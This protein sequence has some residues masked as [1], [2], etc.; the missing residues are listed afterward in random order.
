MGA[1]CQDLGNGYMRCANTPFAG[2]TWLPEAPPAEG[3][4]HELRPTFSSASREFLGAIGGDVPSQFEAQLAARR[5]ADG[6]NGYAGVEADYNAMPENAVTLD[7]TF[8]GPVIGAFPGESAMDAVFRQARVEIAGA[9]SLHGGSASVLEAE[10][11]TMIRGLAHTPDSGVRPVHASPLEEVNVARAIKLKPSSISDLLDPSLDQRQIVASSR[12]STPRVDPQDFQSFGKAPSFDKAGKRPITGEPTPGG[13]SEDD[14]C[15]RLRKLIE[16]GKATVADKWHY[17]QRCKGI[18]PD[19][20]YGQPFP[21]PAG[22]E[23]GD[24]VP[25]AEAP[26][27]AAPVCLCN[28]SCQKP[29]GEPFW[30]GAPNEPALHCTVPQD[31]FLHGTFSLTQSDLNPL[32]KYLI[33]AAPPGIVD[34]VLGHIA[35]RPSNPLIPNS[36]LG[37]DDTICPSDIPFTI[38]PRKPGR[39]TITGTWRNLSC[40]M[41]IR[42][43]DADLCPCSAICDPDWKPSTDAPQ[44]AITVIDVDEST[45]VPPEPV[46]IFDRLLPFEVSLGTSETNRPHQFRAFTEDQLL[47]LTFECAKDEPQYESELSGFIEC[48]EAQRFCAAPS[49]TLLNY[50]TNEAHAKTDMVSEYVHI[51]Y[52]RMG[53]AWQRCA[54]LKVDIYLKCDVA[55]DKARTE[56][57]NQPTVEFQASLEKPVSPTDLGNFIAQGYSHFPSEGRPEWGSVIIKPVVKIATTSLWRAPNCCCVWAKSISVNFIIRWVQ[58]K[59]ASHDLGFWITDPVVRYLT[60]APFTGDLEFNI[61]LRWGAL[62]CGRQNKAGCDKAAEEWRSYLEL[63]VAK[64]A[65]Y[66]IKSSEFTTRKCLAPWSDS[67]EGILSGNLNPALVSGGRDYPTQWWYADWIPDAEA[68]TQYKRQILNSLP[69]A[70]ANALRELCRIGWAVEFVEQVWLHEGE[71][72]AL[73]ILFAKDKY[74]ISCSQ[75][76]FFLQASSVK[77]V[78]DAISKALERLHGLCLEPDFPA[79]VDFLR[80]IDRNSNCVARET[81]ETAGRYMRAQKDPRGKICCV[82]KRF[83]GAV[84][85]DIQKLRFKQFATAVNA[86]V[87][88]LDASDQEIV[89]CIKNCGTND[90][91]IWFGHRATAGAGIIGVEGLG[92]AVERASGMIL[93]LAC[94][95]IEDSQRFKHARS[96]WGLREVTHVAAIETLFRDM[97]EWVEG[98]SSI[99]WGDIRAEIDRRLRLSG[100]QGGYPTLAGNFFS[101]PDFVA[102]PEKYDLKVF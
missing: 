96:F 38:I 87:F 98:N 56:K 42:V 80:S 67:C 10:G 26:G 40:P 85:E 77:D 73:K 89:D 9:N 21:P 28:I 32:D 86:D 49:A 22:M 35:A 4:S 11:T 102:Q 58:P 34:L 62:G 71:T 7:T 100:A 50:M 17:A 46:I 13:A 30:K 74:R 70:Q 8:G 57:G 41:Q 83:A 15:E 61:R 54:R 75:R 36:H 53:G 88:N 12:G 44:C 92:E 69:S 91:F 5:A 97:T 29:E 78:T 14:E 18:M 93:E 39:V 72:Q 31:S 47:D 59:G 94:R 90:V 20:G 82:S 6:S 37:P 55:Q 23:D 76:V 64:L 16:S 84:W 68:S 52:R 27:F 25:P 43:L 19:P 101:R 2:A 48:D 95:S 60:S 45:E 1:Y 65:V 24:N 63:E 3:S 99:T 81:C 51:E 66:M 79:W 33:Y